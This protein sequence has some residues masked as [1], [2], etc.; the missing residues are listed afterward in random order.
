VVTILSDFQYFL[1]RA[2]PP[3]AVV[4][5]S[6]PY[7]AIKNPA[8]NASRPARPESSRQNDGFPDLLVGSD[9]VKQNIVVLVVKEQIDE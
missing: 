6:Q 1:N 7:S 5:M 9:E 3:R 8:L 4:T 2:Y